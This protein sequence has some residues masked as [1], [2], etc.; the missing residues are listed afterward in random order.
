MIRQLWEDILSQYEQED[1]IAL[2]RILSDNAIH[3]IIYDSKLS[4]FVFISGLSRK[5]H[6]IECIRNIIN[7]YVAIS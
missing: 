3:K 4:F 7:Q 2:L 1:W 6:V 5:I